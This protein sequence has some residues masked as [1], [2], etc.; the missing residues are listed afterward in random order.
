MLSLSFALALTVEPASFRGSLLCLAHRPV[1]LQAYRAD[2]SPPMPSPPGLLLFGPVPAEEP[3]PSPSGVVELGPAPAEEPPPAGFSWSLGGPQGAAQG[4]SLQEQR[5]A[6]PGRIRS[7]RRREALAQQAASDAKRNGRA[8]DRRARWEGGVCGWGMSMPGFSIAGHRF[9]PQ[10]LDRT[11]HG[12]I[13]NRCHSKTYRDLSSLDGGTVGIAHFASGSLRTLY[14]Y[15]NTAR[16]FGA[17]ARNIP[18]RP[19]RFAWWREGM[20]RFL[21]SAESRSAQQRA[22][23]AYITPALAAALRHGW[24]SDRELAIAASVANS[25]GAWGFQQLAQQN[26][27]DAER[28]L[29]SYARLSEHKERRRQRL[30]REFPLR[31][32]NT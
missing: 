28:T 12:V 2:P 7:R 20:R 17:H 6:G 11:L 30:D 1:R 15:F 22:W 19:Y 16:Y 21:R 25:L 29:R 9:T 23:R 32:P 31:P 27:W 18:D 4:G 14:Q 24:Q 26:D 8:E 13:A 5:R 3:P 10:W